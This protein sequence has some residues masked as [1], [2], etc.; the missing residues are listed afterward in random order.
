M[1]LELHKRLRIKDR[2][3]RTLDVCLSGCRTWP[4]LDL[5]VVF[6]GESSKI[7]LR[8]LNDCSNAEVLR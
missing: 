4:D 5:D 6:V 2:Y 1:A 8:L 7:S 3:C